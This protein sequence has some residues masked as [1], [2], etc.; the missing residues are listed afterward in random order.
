MLVITPKEKLNVKDLTHTYIELSFVES[1]TLR[2]VA[3]NV[4]DN[5]NDHI[6]SAIPSIITVTKG[7]LKSHHPMTKF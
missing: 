7:S 3:L 5:Q 4:P 6:E 2:K 1:K